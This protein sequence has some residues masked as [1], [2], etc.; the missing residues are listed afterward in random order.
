[1]Y[2]AEQE[3]R[4]K[5][6]E[7]YKELI[8]KL[9]TEE[10]SVENVK[11]IKIDNKSL[12]EKLENKSLELRHLKT[13]L[14][15]VKKENNAHSVALKAS[16]AEIKEQRKEFE[17]KNSELE[18]KVVELNDFRK[19]KLAEERELKIKNRKELKKTNKKLKKEKEISTE[20]S[21]GA[22]DFAHNSTKVDA[23]ENLKLDDTQADDKRNPVEEAEAD[24]INTAESEFVARKKEEAS[25]EDLEV[26]SDNDFLEHLW[27]KFCGQ[28]RPDEFKNQ[29]ESKN[30]SV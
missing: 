25:E 1:M 27:M 17:K 6:D 29:Q 21:D 9:A 30:L 26:M 8:K 15:N 20:E 2:E 5:L 10:K 16:K 18:K 7:E 3:A 11:A 24:P 19:L 28:P 22:I 23:N 14:E 13:E 12:K 4:S